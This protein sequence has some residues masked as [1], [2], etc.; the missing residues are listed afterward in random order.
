MRRG[1]LVSGYVTRAGSCVT[2]FAFDDVRCGRY[3]LQRRKRVDREAAHKSC[4]AASFA[5]SAAKR[6]KFVSAVVMLGIWSEVKE[7]WAPADGGRQARS[8]QTHR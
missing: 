6:I 7:D 4:A 3:V 1:R 5:A 8:I 2:R